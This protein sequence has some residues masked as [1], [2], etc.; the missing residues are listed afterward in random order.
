MTSPGD[1]V[2]AGF[3]KSVARP[4][5]NI[6]G[7]TLLAPELGVKRLELIKAAF[8]EI[9][10]VAV[11]ANPLTSAEQLEQLRLAAP[12]LGIRLTVAEAQA[13]AELDDAFSTMMKDDPQVLL[14]M[15]DPTF[16]ALHNRIADI[17]GTTRLPLVS[18]D[19]ETVEDGGLIAYGAKLAAMFDRVAYYVARILKGANPAELPVEQ[20]TEFELVIIL[21]T[22][23]ALGLTIPLT[24]L[25]RADEVIE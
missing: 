20:P 16:S 11:L 25:A 18:S 9:A 8:P 14:V 17:A 15:S 22:A 24:L 10:R 12:A 19:R 4:G 21:K 7:V 13:P 3:V 23:K 6:T 1:P 2:R 5:G